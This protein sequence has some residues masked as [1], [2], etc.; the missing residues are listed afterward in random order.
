MICSTLS[1]GVPPLEHGASL[2]PPSVVTVADRSEVTPKL[3]LTLNVTRSFRTS[4]FWRGMIHHG[5]ETDFP[6]SRCQSISYSLLHLGAVAVSLSN[7]STNNRV[8]VR[9]A[10]PVVSARFRLVRKCPFSMMPP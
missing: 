2:W 6:R 3:S 1:E 9:F 5:R 10:F 4:Q 8:R 7:T